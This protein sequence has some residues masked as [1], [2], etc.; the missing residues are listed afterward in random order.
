[1]DD[2]SGNENAHTP[3]RAGGRITEATR[4]GLRA[5]LGEMTPRQK[6]AEKAAQALDWVYRFGWSSSTVLGN[7]AGTGRR[8]ALGSRLARNGWLR[9]Q[10]IRISS[11]YRVT[12]TDILTITPLGV[13]E[14]TALKGELPWSHNGAVAHRVVKKNVV[15]DLLV[16]KVTLQYMGKWPDEVPDE[17]ISEY[18]GLVTKFVAEHQF[19]E[20]TSRVKRPDV[21]WRMS[22]GLRLAVE[23]ELSPKYGRELDQ[24]IAGHVR[25]Q[26]SDDDSVHGLVV[27]F[28]SEAALD[29]YTAAMSHGSLIRDWLWDKDQREWYSPPDLPR[30]EI[31]EHFRF[32]PILLP[33]I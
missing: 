24:F 22:G 12:P 8:S 7:I 1:M 6:G 20:S 32:I 27:F 5:A 19:G 29:R 21:I 15:H 17:C 11:S 10:P 33:R 9:R 23:V 13:A 16:Q 25:M 4:E 3:G 30:V 14:L 2:D 31:G 26:Q 28:A 18:Y